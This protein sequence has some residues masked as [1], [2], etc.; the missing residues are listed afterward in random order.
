MKRLADDCLTAGLVLALAGAVTAAPAWERQ[1]DMKSMA[2]SAR[3]VGEL[4]E[5]RRPYSQAEFKEAAE[6]I[7][8]HAGK[9]IVDDFQRP[10]EPDSKAD[11]AMI[12]S[13]ADEFGKL[14]RELEIYAAAL[15]AAADRNPDELG[16]ETRMGG[17]LL[18]SPFG[19]K[20]D[21]ARDAASMPAEHA[22]HLMLQTCTSC[23]A[24]FRKP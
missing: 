22:Y 5:G 19:R 9:R 13:S 17:T 1:A 18:G 4:F 23:H 20:V 2:G 3:I 6:N 21:A 24:K 11:A 7:R 12:A 14:A 10:P 16:P 8:T 15:S